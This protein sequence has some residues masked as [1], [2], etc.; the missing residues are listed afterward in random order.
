MQ[1]SGALQVSLHRPCSCSTLHTE[2]RAWQ[3]FP[4]SLFSTVKLPDR[5]S[6]SRPCFH[7]SRM[8]ERGSWRAYFTGQ[9]VYAPSS[10]QR[11]PEQQRLIRPALYD[12]FGLAW[13]KAP[14][15]AGRLTFTN[16][17]EGGVGGAQGSSH[18][19]KHCASC[20]FNQ[21]HC[22]LKPKMQENRGEVTQE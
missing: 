4:G 16:R 6:A 8:A 20:H 21:L 12:E 17:W 11:S 9:G 1:L 5:A 15:A 13:R 22:R 18:T 2:C 19:L 7:L 14:W 10:Q 3:C